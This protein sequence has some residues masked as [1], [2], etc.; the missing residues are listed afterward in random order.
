[1]LPSSSAVNS[2]NPSFSSNDFVSSF[3]DH[4]YIVV[5]SDG[6]GVVQVL[7][8]EQDLTTP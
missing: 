6:E 2:F 7:L 5:E 8:N 1:M 4:F 3:D